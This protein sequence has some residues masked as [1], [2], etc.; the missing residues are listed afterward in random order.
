MLKDSFSSKDQN[1]KNIHNWTVA[2]SQSCGEY[3]TLST[4]QYQ[5]V[6]DIHSESIEDI[7]LSAITTNALGVEKRKELSHIENTNFFLALQTKG[8]SS[9]DQFGNHVVLEKGDAILMDQR[10]PCGYK[11]SKEIEHLVVRVPIESIEPFIGKNKIITGKKIDTR[12]GYGFNIKRYMQTS[13]AAAKNN[14]ELAL[15]INQD[16]LIRLIAS[17]TTNGNIKLSTQESQNI[18]LNE[19]KLFIQKNLANPNLSINQ[20]AEN[21]YISR[22]QLYNLFEKNNITPYEWLKTQRL[23][24]ALKLLH[25][26]DYKTQPISIIAKLSGFSDLSYFSRL[27][28]KHHN[29]SPAKYRADNNQP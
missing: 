20:I 17:Q 7:Q 22:R 26:N 4:N 11:F 3:N 21:N 24:H 25:S 12:T 29:K 9:F 13:Y 19:V 14:N 23:N 10:F 15:N 8:K 1:E 28:S 18:R 6:G 5:F 2:L 16:T 27:F